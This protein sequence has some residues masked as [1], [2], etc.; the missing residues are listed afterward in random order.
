MPAQVVVQN[1]QELHAAVQRSLEDSVYGGNVVDKSQL[2]GMSLTKG[3]HP[4][5][6]LGQVQTP[7]NL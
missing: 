5:L 7:L 6:P 3:H 4:L 1:Q 2:W